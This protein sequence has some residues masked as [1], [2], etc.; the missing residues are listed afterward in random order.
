MTLHIV[1][2][3]AGLGKRMYSNM[4]KVLHPLAGKSMIR[5]VCETAKQLNPEAIHVIYGHGGAEVMDAMSD[6]AIH[7]I[8][9]KEQLGTGHALSQAL[10]FLPDEATVLVLSADVPLIQ[11]ETL[12]RLLHSSAAHVRLVTAELDNPQGL[13]RIVRDTFGNIRAIVEEKDADDKERAIREIYSGICAVAASDLK[14]WLPRLHSDNAQS[15]YYLTDIIA[16]AAEEGQKLA[17]ILVH[18]LYEIQGVNNRLQLQQLERL[19][20]KKEAERL[21]LSGVHIMDTAR[22]DLRGELICGKDVFIDINCVFIGRVVL[23]DGCRIGP[24]CVLSNVIVEEG[25]II[26]AHSLIEESEIGPDCH[27]GP[28]SRLRPQTQLARNCKIGNFVETKKTSLC[29]GSKANHLSYLGDARIGEAVNIGAGTI[30]C[31]YDGAHKHETIIDAGAFIGSGTQLVAPVHV[32]ADAVIG[33]GTVVRHDAPA[34]ALTVS[35]N[36]QKTILGW[37]KRLARCNK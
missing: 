17:S 1:I 9:Q 21:L 37:K 16:M 12:N 29:A 26:Y 5:W 2:L 18:D 14:R 7:W 30:T 34:G 11:V 22:F 36:K 3:A 27:I 35:E 15:E 13:G 10:P 24:H 19:W 8:H 33:A 32:G 28:F 20:Q 25:T 23:G 31:N 4:P 6:Y